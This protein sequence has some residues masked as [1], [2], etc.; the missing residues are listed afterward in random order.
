MKGKSNLPTFRHA[1]IRSMLDFSYFHIRYTLG[2]GMGAMVNIGAKMGRF[3]LPVLCSFSHSQR[4]C[5]LITVQ[6]YVCEF[7]PPTSKPTH[8]HI[9]L[10]T[11]VA[12]RP[13]EFPRTYLLRI[14]AIYSRYL[15]RN[16]KIGP[17]RRRVK[18][19]KHFVT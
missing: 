5:M 4:K 8:A 18:I 2:G 15:L 17:R 12:C 7:F 1:G 3:Y 9:E 16:P 6:E 19:K 13:C 14:Y 11:A 10:Q